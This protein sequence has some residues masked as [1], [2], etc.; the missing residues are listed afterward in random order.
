MPTDVAIVV[1]GIS[2]AFALFAAAL[3]WADFH[4]GSA[5]K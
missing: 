5:R 3:A 4:S 2:A 1:A